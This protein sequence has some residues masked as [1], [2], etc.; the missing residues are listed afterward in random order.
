MFVSPTDVKLND[1]TIV[2]P[3]IFV[4]CD[5]SRFDK[6]RYNGAPDLVIEIVST[7][8]YKDFYRNI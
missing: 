1:T 7:D 6:Q 2:V 8:R 4:V 3:D 5:N